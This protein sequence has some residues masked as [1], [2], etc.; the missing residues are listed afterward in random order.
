MDRYSVDALY[1]DPPWMGPTWDG[2]HILLRV[3][4][5]YCQ[6]VEVEL[7]ATPGQRRPMDR[8][9]S[10]IH[11]LRLDPEHWGQRYWLF[12]DGQRRRADP[13]SRS[14]PKGVH[15]PSRL[16]DPAFDWHD[17]AWS[18]QARA[19]YVIYEL[20]CGTF[21]TSADFSGVGERLGELVDLGVTAIELMPVAQFP[22][23]RNW[24]YD[25]VFPY[26]VQNSYGGPRG[27]KRLVDACHQRGLGVVLD[28]VYNHLGP[29]G[30]YLAEFGPYFTD[31]YH[32]PWG[33]ALNFDGHDS[34]QVRRFFIQNALYWIT[35][36]HIDGLRLDAIQMIFD[37]SARPFL[38]DLA[39]AVERKASQLG[40]TVCLWGETNQNDVRQITSTDQGGIGLDGL[41]NDDFH[42]ALHAVITGENVSV[43]R[44]HGSIA[45]VAD[46][47]RH[48][49]VLDGRFS[50]HQRRHHGSSSASAAADQFVIFAQNHDQIGNR[51]YGDRLSHLVDL[52]ALKLTAALM[53]LAPNV[54]MLFM[55]EEYAEQAPFLYF[56]SHQDAHLL[57]AVRRGRVRD[58][59]PFQQ[60]GRPF[61]TP[62]VRKHLNLAV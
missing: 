48:G 20:H 9:E 7:L 27:L 18:G 50:I 57:R 29:E 10:G 6:S 28:V 12:L 54:P 62:P 1:L 16:V 22:G 2:E 11:S 56:V 49:F 59:Q 46:A 3:W 55:G 21:S 25:G 30:N 4:A 19:D 40:R 61:P 13:A 60:P 39:A 58:C 42:H 41:W 32:T 43:Y 36:F 8:D 51:L 14:Q 35:E 33:A 26:A 52:E 53:L 47:Y 38:A 23:S 45:N 24:G 5:P 17:L 34:D 31:R 15:G 37:S 44:D